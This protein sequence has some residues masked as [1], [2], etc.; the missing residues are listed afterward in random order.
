MRASPPP[1]R[2]QTQASSGRASWL[3]RVSP[4]QTGVDGVAAALAGNLQVAAGEPLNL[5][6]ARGRQVAYGCQ[7]LEF[8]GDH[9]QGRLEAHLVVPC[10][11]AAVGQSVE[12]LLDRTPREQ[13]RGQAALGADA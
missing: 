13:L 11:R 6:L 1:S 2:V 8:G 7:H 4:P 5:L 12:T 3:L 9:G 10:G